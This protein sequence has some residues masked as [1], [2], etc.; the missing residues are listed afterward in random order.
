MPQLIAQDRDGNIAKLNFNNLPINK[1]ITTFEIASIDLKEYDKL[2]ISSD[3]L[4][5]N[6]ILQSDRL[7]YSTVEDDLRN[8]E[9]IQELMGRFSQKT[10]QGRDDI[11]LFYFN[12][13]H[14]QD[15]LLSK[16]TYQA[17]LEQVQKA[18]DDF[19][20]KLQKSFQIDASLLTRLVFAFNELM[21]NAYEHGCLEI[22]HH[23]KHKIIAST[24]YIEYLLECERVHQHKVI[25]AKIYKIFSDTHPYLMVSI[26]DPG[27]GFDVTMLREFFYRKNSQFNGRG[28]YM[29]KSV[30]DSIYFNSTANQVIF[31]K[32]L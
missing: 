18:N 23:Q 29:S 19:T 14:L 26:E 2:L 22:T 17:T 32:K 6:K 9:T 7:Y 15:T 31:I 25:T 5:E 27:N 24:D 20:V 21:M 1:Y 30:I 12:R 28:L 11:T 16:Q 8:S 13:V 3:G 10:E 4:F